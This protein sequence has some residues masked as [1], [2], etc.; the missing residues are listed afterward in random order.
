MAPDLWCK[1]GWNLAQDSA[2]FR[3]YVVIQGSIR[4]KNIVLES[5]LPAGAHLRRHS[6]QREHAMQQAVEDRACSDRLAGDR[7]PPL[8]QLNEGQPYTY[9]R[10]E[11]VKMLDDALAHAPP[12][13]NQP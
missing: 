4:S 13:T 11:L 10:A 9:S 5:R 12:R 2:P 1:L 3:G 6:A 8:V 7:V